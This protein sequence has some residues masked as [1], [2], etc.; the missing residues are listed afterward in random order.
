MKKTLSIIVALCMLIPLTVCAK[1]ENPFV[2][3]SEDAWYHDEVV[4]AVE[5]GIINGKTATEFKPDDLLTYA[6]AIKLAACMNQ[7]YTNGEVTLAGGEPWYMPYVEYCMENGITEK[8]YE[9]DKNTTRADYMTIFANALPDEAFEEINTIPDGSILDVKNNAPYAIYVYKL[10]RAGI[11]TGV[12]ALHNCNPDESIRRSEVATIISRMMDESARKEFDMPEENFKKDDHNDIEFDEK[13]DTSVEVKTEPDDTP[14]AETGDTE[15]KTE[16]EAVVVKP[17]D[18][19]NYEFEEDN[20]NYILSVLTIYKQPKG[21]ECEEYGSEYELEVQVYGGKAPY[22]YEWQYNGYR[23]QKTKIENG[24]YADNADSAVLILS[25]EKENKLLGKSISCKITDS[26]GTTVTTDTI[27]VYGPFSMP[28]DDWTLESGKNT[29]IGRVADGILK[30]GEKVSVIRDGKV[31]AIGVA[32]DLQMFNK[33]MDETVKDDNVG[34]VFERDD[35]VRPGTGDIVVKYKD[36]HIIDTSD[37][38]N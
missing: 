26:E 12:D 31:I 16:H 36:T 4:K 10:Y 28:V 2:D 27:K 20:N 1:T 23:N 11:V 18:S 5:T 35:G 22:T 29:L 3:V 6:E 25:V 9:Y 14:V 17:V 38:V 24:D 30:K 8:E 7:V 37:I 34:I 33:S 19:G 32:E 21:S 13:K 15:I